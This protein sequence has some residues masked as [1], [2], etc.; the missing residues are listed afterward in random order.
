MK[1]VEELSHVRRHQ[2]TRRVCGFFLEL[3]VT[4]EAAGKRREFA[5]GAEGPEE[6]Y[7]LILEDM[8]HE[9]DWTPAGTVV[10]APGAGY[11]DPPVPFGKQK[12]ASRFSR[13]TE[14]GVQ[15]Q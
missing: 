4:L 3:C 6:F 14:G 11:G 2:G 1:Y 12:E 15:S 8:A 9:D 7:D 5:D 10:P 13:R